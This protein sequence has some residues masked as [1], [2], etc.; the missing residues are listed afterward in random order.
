MAFWTCPREEISLGHVH[1]YDEY[2]E[3]VQGQYTIVLEDEKIPLGIGQE[4]YL[5]AGVPHGGEF[6]AGTRTFHA[7][8]GKLAEQD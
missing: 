3:V 7:F 5:P 8:G 1:D 6:I 4:Y 2:S